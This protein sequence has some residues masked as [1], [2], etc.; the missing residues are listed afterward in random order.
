METQAKE[1]M[2]TMEQHLLHLYTHGII[3]K[4][5]AITYTNEASLLG[6]GRYLQTVVP[7][8]RT[9][10]EH[11][12]GALDPIICLVVLSDRS[13]ATGRSFCIFS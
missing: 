12:R 9:P 6:G 1:G 8:L 5:D 13:P 11:A 10:Y 2:M 7:V 4:E 3:T